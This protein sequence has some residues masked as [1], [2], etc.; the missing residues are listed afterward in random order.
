MF[1][2]PPVAAVSEIRFLLFNRTLSIF[3]SPFMVNGQ[4]KFH[5]ISSLSL[6]LNIS[7]SSGRSTRC[8]NFSWRGRKRLKSL[9]AMSYKSTKSRIRSISSLQLALKEIDFLKF[10]L[11]VPAH[12]RHLNS[13]GLVECTIIHILSLLCS[14]FMLFS[15]HV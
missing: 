13:R 11:L 6:V 14:D 10:L 7:I 12:S 3:K 5:F 2:L 15:V 1:E 4:F 9:S 8:R